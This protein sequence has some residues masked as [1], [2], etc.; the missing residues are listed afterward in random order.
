[1]ARELCP[2]CGSSTGL[3]EKICF[4][5]GYFNAEYN[6]SHSMFS[7]R[8]YTSKR[9]SILELEDDVMF[10]VNQFSPQALAWLY[11][12]S[13][14]DNIIS[15][16]MIGYCKNTNK[17]LIPAF[18]QNNT[19]QFYQLRALNPN[20][21][22]YLTY[23]NTANY[24][25]HYADHKDSDTIIICEDHLS[26][27]RVREFENVMCLSGTTLKNSAIENILENYTN[28]VFWLD[29]DKPGRDAMFKNYNRLIKASDSV[30]RKG[31][32]S[33]L[34]FR[35]YTFSHIDYKTI[36]KDPKEYLNSEIEYIIQD[37]R[38]PL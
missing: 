4:K 38:V 17:V 8:I 37:K 27:I 1:M 10:S 2:S 32:F 9:N 26:T 13:I 6:I 19:L 22:K 34:K 14:Y 33:N 5:C 12:Y 25:I 24:T 20:E 16:Q 21:I 18:D 23:G 7:D 11:K 28:V 36:A 30:N 31:L 35:T 29:A 3:G 15:K